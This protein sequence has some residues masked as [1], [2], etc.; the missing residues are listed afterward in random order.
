MAFVQWWGKFQGVMQLMERDVPDFAGALGLTAAARRVIDKGD[1][2]RT[3]P[4]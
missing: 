3:V 4:V 2:V 1:W